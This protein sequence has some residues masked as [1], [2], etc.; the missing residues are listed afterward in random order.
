MEMQR[1]A[2]PSR[3]TTALY[4]LITAI[5][6]VVGPPDDRVAVATVVHLLRATRLT[7][8]GTASPRGGKTIFWYGLTFCPVLGLFI[9]DHGRQPAV[10]PAGHSCPGGH[11]LL[12]REN[13]DG[14]RPR[15]YHR[16]PS[17][18]LTK[19]LCKRVS[20]CH[21]QAYETTYLYSSAD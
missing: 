8:R 6:D 9:S 14:S 3:L 11:G 20:L 13:H 17:A 12:R 4:D 15:W 1:E 10:V 5:Q 19:V 2:P 16:G 18:G 21:A 7:G